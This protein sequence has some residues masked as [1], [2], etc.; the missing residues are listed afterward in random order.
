[1]DIKKIGKFL[2][3]GL[4]TVFV[5]ALAAMGFVFFDV[6]SYTA[7]GSETLNPDGSSNG[8]A[9]VVYDP[10]ISGES[11]DIANIIGKK[12]QSKG[13]TVKLAGIRSDVAL[14]TSDYEYIVVGG[15]IYAGSASNS[16]KD[17]LKT[18]QDTSKTTIGVFASGNDPDTAKNNATLL[19]E[20]APL[21]GNSSL[22]IKAVIKVVTSE[23]IDDQD[24]NAFINQLLK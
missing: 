10:G 13:Y 9:L 11:K 14:N 3:I 2:G 7:T 21:P 18:L 4:I 23:G 19:K 17:Y 22:Q 15:P 1:M 6:M 5:V 16:V 8:D 20:A 24:I 12:L